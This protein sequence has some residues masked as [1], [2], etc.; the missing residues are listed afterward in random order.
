[1]ATPSLHRATASIVIHT[2]PEAAFDAWL[3]PRT[4][5][6]FVAPDTRSVAL[7]ESEPREG[8]SFRLVMQGDSGQIAHEGRYVLVDRP[9]RLIFTWIS[10]GTDQRLSLV[11]VLFTPTDGG[12]RIDLEHEGLPDAERADRHAGGWRS[13]LER[14]SHSLQ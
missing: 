5:S 6:R 4:A 8:G 13:I 3:D 2:S 9:R 7:F 1:M 12:V 11:T 14:L 10:P